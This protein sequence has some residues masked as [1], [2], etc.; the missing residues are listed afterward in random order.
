MRELIITIQDADQRLD[1][2]LQKAIP[3]LPGILAQKYIRQ[4]RIRLNGKRAQPK[5]RLAAGDVI[6]LYIPAD[7][8]DTPKTSKTYQKTAKPKLDICYEDRQILIINKAPN[9][10]CHSGDRPGAVTLVDQVKA[11]L[12]HSGAW[13][14][15]DSLSFAPALCNRLDRNT[16]GLVIAAKT[17]AALKGINEKIRNLEVEKS[18]LLAVHGRPNPPTGMIYAHM[19]KDQREK[20][21]TVIAH[22]IIA[23]EQGEGADAQADTC[24]AKEKL[25]VLRYDTLETTDENLSLVECQLITGR[26]HQIRAQMAAIGCPVL[27][28]RKYGGDADYK[29]EPQQALWAWQIR[30]AFTTDAGELEYLN[31]RR[32]RSPHIPFL[33]RYFQGGDYPCLR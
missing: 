18:Y 26:F 6:A 5:D 8:F 25:A 28:D 29:Q 1:R 19:R 9:L 15:E 7:C 10:L 33:A 24:Q 3:G 22:E 32:F 30:F 16:G 14:P 11:Y 12:Y 27:G 20:K 4:K 13:R 17:A 21:S 31:G 2:F 23:A